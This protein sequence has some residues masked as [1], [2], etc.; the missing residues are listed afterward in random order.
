VLT[1]V[2]FAAAVGTK[3]Q[4]AAVAICIAPALIW[5]ARSRQLATAA[6]VG[7]FAFLLLGGA[8]YLSNVV[9]ERT[10]IGVDSGMKRET[11]IAYGDWANLWQGPYVLIAAPFAPK[12]NELPV[13]WADR[14]WFWR[15]YELFFSHLGIPFALCAIAMPFAMI[16]LRR[17]ASVESLVISASVLI[18]F[19]IMLPVNFQPHG[20]FAISLPRYALFVVPIVFG[21]TIAP[22]AQRAPAVLAVIGVVALTLYSIDIVRN[23]AFAPWAYVQFVRAHP[24]TRQVPFDPFRAAE[25]A[26]RRAGQHDR[27]AIDAAFGT[28]I[29][30]AFGVQ[31][32]RPV[33]FIPAGEGPPLIREDADWVVIDRGWKILW[34]HPQFRDLSQARMFLVRG[35]PAPE[36]TRVLRYLRGDRRF[37]LVFYNPVWNQAVFQ[38]IR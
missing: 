14:P 34:E 2:A 26:D 4:G 23:D 1:V 37:R 13:P 10:V 31:L 3:P 28:W 38:R 18:A 11:V 29:H 19:A 27:I 7:V 9:N 36:D 16:A 17:R 5:R 32:D 12:P 33:D 15:R 30:P 6:V 8:V 24:Q 22:L 25:V 20:M 35:Q 21:W